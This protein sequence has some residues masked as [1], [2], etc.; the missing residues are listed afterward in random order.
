MSTFRQ[1]LLESAPTAAKTWQALS[2]VTT[3]VSSFLWARVSATLARR[4]CQVF[5][6]PTRSALRYAP[7]RRTCISRAPRGL[8]MLCGYGRYARHRR[9]AG[10]GQFD[11]DL[12]TV[13]G[14]H[15]G[16]LRSTTRATPAVSEMERADLS[17]EDRQTVPQV[18]SMAGRHSGV[19]PIPR[20]GD[21]D[22]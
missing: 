12:R 15:L 5:A 6:G 4:L 16:G 20:P 19:G 8:R 9:P 7:V 11:G 18:S 13:P 10:Q 21:R 2:P 1:T 17:A 22:L 3:M 14:R